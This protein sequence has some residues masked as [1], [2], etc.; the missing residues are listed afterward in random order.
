MITKCNN[1]T[2]FQLMTNLSE[3]PHFDWYSH[4]MNLNAIVICALVYLDNVFVIGELNFHY[5]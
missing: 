4:S 5:I 1:P 3:P 2:W